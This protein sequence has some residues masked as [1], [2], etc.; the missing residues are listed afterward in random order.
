[1]SYNENT[2]LV[3]SSFVHTP[4]KDSF[5]VINDGW[6][7]VQDGIIEGLYKTRPLGSVSL[8]VIHAEDKLVIPS[9]VDLHVHGP[10]YNQ[11]GMGMDLELIQ[12]LEQYTFPEE[13]KY[14]SIDYA[15]E[16]YSAFVN[17]LA[18]SGTTRAAIF[19]TIHRTSDDA[20]CRILAQ[21][22]LCAYVGKVNMDTNSPHTLLED[23]DTSIVETEQF[24]QTWQHHPSVRPIV[25]PRFAPTST[26]IS[27]EALGKLARQYE[28]PVQSH[29]SENRDE[30]KWVAS[31]FPERASYADVYD[32]YGLYGQTPTLMAHCIHVTEQEMEDMAQRNVYAIHCPDS[33]INLSSGLMPLKQMMKRGVK[34]GFGS[35]IGAG[36]SLFMPQT[37][38]RAIQIS[39]IRSMTYGKDE[40]LR[41]S[42]AF[43]IATK[44]SGSFFGCVGSFERG[45]DADFLVLSIPPYEQNVGTYDRFQSF[46]YKG[47]AQSVESVY[48]K[49]KKIKTSH[50]S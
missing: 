13:S 39:K 35:D 43:Y 5:S 11:I 9:F 36:H 45:Y 27:L 46:I 44:G 15:Q 7:L 1:M 6:L 33:N 2:Y 3:H 50:N 22:G 25:T 17:D 40:V 42:E 41:L 32:H 30:I 26:R 16:M 48:C 47:T 12:W 34:V 31:L 38:V 8:P 14:A 4:T 29:L 20:L 21:K 10:Q 37:I 49:G 18:D 24:I 19:G 23:T 28:V